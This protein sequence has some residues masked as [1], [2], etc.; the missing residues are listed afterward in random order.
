MGSRFWLVLMKGTVLYRIFIS[1]ERLVTIIWTWLTRLVAITLPYRCT[2]FNLQALTAVLRA[3][4]IYPHED[5]FALMVSLLLLHEKS[6]KVV[7][8]CE[9]AIRLEGVWCTFFHDTVN[10]QLSDSQVIFSALAYATPDHSQALLH[11]I[12]LALAQ[13]STKL[14]PYFNIACILQV[15][16]DFESA[17][18]KY[19]IV[20]AE[21]PHC[22]YLYNN[23]GLSYYAL[24]K[25]LAVSLELI[26]G[27]S[28]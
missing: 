15:L 25:H 2:I 8:L 26:C 10:R 23:V 11:W 22:A 1:T 3:I 17:S 16:G 4:Q 24:S 12:R 6:E 14:E 18:Y 19:R 28:Y 5:A 9:E 7:T 21:N 20:A 13:S 27:I